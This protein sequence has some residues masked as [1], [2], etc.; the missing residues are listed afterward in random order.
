MSDRLQRVKL[1]MRST[2]TDERT[3]GGMTVARRRPGRSTALS[4]RSMRV[5][6]DLERA[7][8]ESFSG[9]ERVNHL[10]TVLTG[11]GEDA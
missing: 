4:D 6:N 7:Y 2:E 10:L 5:R 9:R 3:H 11:K 8:Q 1:I